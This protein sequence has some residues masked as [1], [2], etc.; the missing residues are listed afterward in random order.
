MT[1]DDCNPTDVK[2]VLRDVIASVIAPDAMR[3]DVEGTFP[4]PGLTALGEAGLL[5]LTVAKEIGGGGGGPGVAAAVH[6]RPW[7]G[8]AARPPWSP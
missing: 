3:V 6:S 2:E 4:Q 1:V 7:R 5:G 8:P